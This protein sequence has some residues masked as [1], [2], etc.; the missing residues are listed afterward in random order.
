MA[1][2]ASRFSWGVGFRVPLSTTSRCC[3]GDTD[4]EA[5]LLTARLQAKWRNSLLRSNYLVIASAA[6]KVLAIGDR[7]FVD[8]DYHTSWQHERG[9][10]AQSVDAAVNAGRGPV[11]WS[12][13]NHFCPKP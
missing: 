10:T 11:S 12:L 8:A 4:S 6:V 5:G 13:S 2:I 9:Q 7:E 1:Y 3:A